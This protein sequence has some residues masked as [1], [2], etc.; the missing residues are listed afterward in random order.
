MCQERFGTRTKIKEL[1]VVL[2]EKMVRQIIACSNTLTAALVRAAE[3]QS[4]EISSIFNREA[5]QPTAR[6]DCTASATQGRA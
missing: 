6:Q 3:A 4:Y 5:S 1:N 2:G